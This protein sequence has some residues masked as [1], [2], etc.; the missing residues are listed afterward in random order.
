MFT[1]QNVFVWYYWGEGEGPVP[2]YLR[3][4]LEG[5]VLMEANVVEAAASVGTVTCRHHWRI[6]PPQGPVSMG[7][8]LRCGEERE[9][10]N[11]A[12][13]SVWDNDH[14]GDSGYGRYRARG[15]GKAF[16][17]RPE[18][19]LYRERPKFDIGRLEGRLL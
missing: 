12:Q 14:S 17:I 18:E 6:E 7:Q 9:F 8:C 13:E 10:R 16:S 19:D 2:A 1:V 15:A 3:E 4:K 5:N 11:S